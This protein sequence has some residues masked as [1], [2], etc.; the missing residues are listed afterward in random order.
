MSSNPSHSSRSSDELLLNAAL[1]EYHALYRLAEFRLNAL[2]RR[3]P[4]IGGLLTASLSSV[5]LLPGSSQTLALIAIPVSL[6]WLVR[7]T[8]NHARSFEDALRGV[9]RAEHQI[10][11]MLGQDVLGFQRTHP[12]KGKS[13]GGRTGAETVGAVGLASVLI[14]AMS[15]WM[16]IGMLTE[17]PNPQ[18]MIVLF[19]VFI[20]GICAM[21]THSVHGWRVYRYRVG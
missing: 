16:T 5:P 4:I 7:T 1:A 20:L 6:I 2:D 11:R 3:V 13:V 12:S 8:I 18:G 21:I 14:L 19:A 10:N 15:V 9:E 17:Q